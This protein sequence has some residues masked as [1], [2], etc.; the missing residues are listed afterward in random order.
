M[1]ASDIKPIT[2]LKTHA[3]ELVDKVNEKRSPV[4]ITQN[5]EPRAVVVDIQSY[6]QTQDAF[7][8]LKLISQSEQDLR[9]GKFLSQSQMEALLKKRFGI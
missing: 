9:K 5:G 3:A 7:T 8:L 4:V 6:E 1:R 2:Y